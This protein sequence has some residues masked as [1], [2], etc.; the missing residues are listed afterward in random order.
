MQVLEQEQMD[1]NARVKTFPRFAAG[2]FLEI[3]LVRTFAAT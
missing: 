2:D 1:L 3:K